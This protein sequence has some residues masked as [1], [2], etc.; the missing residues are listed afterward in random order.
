MESVG[1]SIGQSVS[2]DDVISQV[3]NSLFRIG[4]ANARL[5]EVD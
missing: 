4:K 2:H 1:Q 3:Q 5:L